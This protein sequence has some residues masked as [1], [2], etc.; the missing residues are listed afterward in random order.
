MSC[1]PV[2]GRGVERYDFTF[3]VDTLCWGANFSDASNYASAKINVNGEEQ[4]IADIYPGG[5]GFL[6]FFDPGGMTGFSLLPGG[7]PALFED[8]AFQID[9]L[10]Y[11]VTVSA[12]PE[13]SSACFLGLV[14][15]LHVGTN[16]LKKS[17]QSFVKHQ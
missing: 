4:V 6:G 3:N 8:E 12:V 9:N 7:V 13:P 1:I 10:E 16:S 14:V 5:D 2:A 11:A 15:L 17:R